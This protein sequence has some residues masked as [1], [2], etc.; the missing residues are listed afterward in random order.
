MN[1]PLKPK[2]IDESTVLLDRADYDALLDRL[3]DLEDAAAIAAGRRSDPADY[4]PLAVVEAELSGNHPLRAWRR[5]RGR[6]LAELATATGVT[7]SHLSHVETR[8]TAASVK[9]LRMLAD[10]LDV[11]IDDL[12][13]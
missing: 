1:T 13:P 6:T 3:E 7:K 11:T 2:R 8:R 12:I 10:E 4:V 5:Y 9:L